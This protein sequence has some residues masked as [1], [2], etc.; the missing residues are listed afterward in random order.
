MTFIKNHKILAILLGAFL[1][2]NILWLINHFSFTKPDGD[3]KESAN[4]YYKPKDDYTISYKPPSYPS[5]EGNYAISTEGDLLSVLI[6]PGTIFD[7]TKE[8]GVSV[9]DQANNQGYMFYIDENLNFINGKSGLS[10]DEDSKAQELFKAQHQEL[11]KL[12][13]ILEDEIN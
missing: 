7:K 6:W 9:Y 11:S 3:F 5:F 13:E 10:V 2:F 8:Y 1:I 12:V 4:A